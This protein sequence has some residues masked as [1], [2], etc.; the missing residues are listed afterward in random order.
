[1]LLIVLF[2]T[3]TMN[4]A[5]FISSLST[6]TLLF[7]KYLITLEMNDRDRSICKKVTCRC[8]LVFDHGYL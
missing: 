6:R 1:M 3:I 7:G 2:S 4:R 5:K 8:K